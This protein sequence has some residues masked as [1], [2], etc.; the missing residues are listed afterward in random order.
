[1]RSLRSFDERRA[2]KAQNIMF[3]FH[4]PGI[5]VDE[6]LELVLVEKFPG[7]PDIGFVPAYRFEMRFAN[8]GQ[9]IG[10]IE[11]RVGNTDHIVLY[12]GHLAYGVDA[13]H[14]GHRFAARA[15]KLLLPLAQSHDLNPLW[16]TCD[17]AN[18]ASRR[19][20][21]LAGAQF[22]EI[23]ELPADT[24]L[25]QRGFRRGCRYRLDL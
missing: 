8:A 19:T 12:G 16:I 15:C 22:V 5:L 25:Y 7:D 21:E 6:D 9:A 3:E 2:I 14:R 20:C 4:P 11:L 24:D 23:V 1:M 18:I 17:P 13:E 10:K